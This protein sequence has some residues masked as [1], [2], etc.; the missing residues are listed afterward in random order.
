MKT[1]TKAEKKAIMDR[2]GSVS[3]ADAFTDEQWARLM[4][5]GHSEVSEIMRDIADE[6]AKSGKGIKGMKKMHCFDSVEVPEW[7]GECYLTDCK[8][9]NKDEPMCGA[10]K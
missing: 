5:A 2:H 6:N 10:N 8:W 1:P 7:G 3:A 4:W 9:H